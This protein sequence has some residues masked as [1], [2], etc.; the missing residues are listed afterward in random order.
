M[1]LPTRFPP[2]GVRQGFFPRPLVQGCQ[3]RRPGNERPASCGP[4]RPAGGQGG[5]PAPI[6]P[7]GRGRV[8][9]SAGS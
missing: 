3:G 6:P 2:E 9:K 7:G 4:S 1:F 8:T 5:S